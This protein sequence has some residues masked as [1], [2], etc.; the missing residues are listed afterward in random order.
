MKI[1]EVLYG[2]PLREDDTELNGSTNQPP[3]IG[4]ADAQP[5]GQVGPSPTGYL[6]R[7]ASTPS[8]TQ[9]DLSVLDRPSPVNPQ[10]GRP[11]PG[12][13]ATAPGYSKDAA[14]DW[15]Y[16]GRPPDRMVGSGSLLVPAWNKPVSPAEQ[17]ASRQEWLKANDTFD[18]TRDISGISRFV[19]NNTTAVGARP[20]TNNLG[21]R[22][23]SENYYQDRFP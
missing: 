20:M 14:G 9:P 3:P 22:Q 1:I 19:T 13:G 10:T 8:T 21:W 4:F 18:K 6:G 17:E 7:S 16:N 23:K 11:S 5:P 12:F 2:C 15:T